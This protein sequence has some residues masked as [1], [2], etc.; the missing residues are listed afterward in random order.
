MGEFDLNKM[1]KE[2]IPDPLTGGS[3]T[4]YTNKE[5]TFMMSIP[6][7]AIPLPEGFV[8]PQ[9]KRTK[10]EDGSETWELIEA[11]NI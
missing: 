7:R 10:N 2:V 9:Y 6:D 5:G 3:Q 8:A 4:I 1:N 11:K